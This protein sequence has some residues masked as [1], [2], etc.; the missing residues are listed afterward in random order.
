[1]N[2]NP[3]Y[4]REHRVSTRSLKLSIAILIFNFIIAAVTL[5]EMND[6]VDF[7][8]KTSFIDYTSFLQI[9]RLVI[10]VPALLLVFVAPSFIAGTI[11]DERQRGTLEI[12]LTTKMTAKSI[13]FG[14]FLSLFASIMLILISQLPI[15]AILFL[16][17]GITV[18]D[19]VKL[20][21][22]FVVFVVL[23]I[24][25][26]IFCSSI[27]R[28][29]SVATALLYSGVLGLFIGTLILYFLAANSFVM[30][31][32]GLFE[33]VFIR[34]SKF[35]LL[36]NPLVSIDFLLSNIMGEESSDILVSLFWYKNWYYINMILDLGLSFMFL[37]LSILK[38]KPHSKTWRKHGNSNL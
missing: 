5:I 15:L 37:A 6:V 25:M 21:I 26:G 8:R 9:F 23:I 35:V 24:S 29:N 16:Y 34:F 19:I 20:I 30:D 17:G 32:S 14:K 10:F 31:E 38:I 1:M 12:L 3:I 36:F 22:N 11:S 7:A 27:A 33:I 13:V 18:L 28:K 4:E 2:I